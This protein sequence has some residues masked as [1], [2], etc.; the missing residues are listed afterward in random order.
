MFQQTCIS[1][2][3]QIQSVNLVLGNVNVRMFWMQKPKLLFLFIHNAMAI[4]C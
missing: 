4:Q 3:F 1:V 2:M